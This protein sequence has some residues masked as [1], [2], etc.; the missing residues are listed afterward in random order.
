LAQVPFVRQVVVLETTA[1]TN[2]D[3]RRLAADGAPEGTV[4]LAGRQ[5][6]GRGRRGRHWESSEDVGLYLSVLLRPEEPIDGIGRYAIAAAVAA[7]TACRRFAGERVLLKWPND[8]LAHGRKLAGILSELRQGPSGAELVL[9]LGVNVNQQDGDFAP[10]LRTVATSLRILRYGAVVDRETVA[11]AL[12]AELG[13]TIVG[14]RST[15]WR[16]VTERFL[17]YAPHAIGCRVRLASG[18]VGI[19]DGLDGAGALRVATADGIVVV[20]ASESVTLAGE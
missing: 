18:V 16:Q 20:H 10:S 1:S 4:V 5:T 17:G 12:L 6:A 3:A 19:T 13:A 9:G 15:G 2:D 8:L 14:M 7:C 11:A